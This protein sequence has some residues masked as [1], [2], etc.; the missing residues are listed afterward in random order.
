MLTYEGVHGVPYNNIL[1]ASSWR[2][3]QER[4]GKVSE[5]GE[6][7]EGADDGDWKK[8]ERRKPKGQSTN[9]RRKNQI[10]KAGKTNNL[11]NQE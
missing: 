9:V 2:P 4:K 3:L 6:K 1:V 11:T 10:K 7:V 8:E 5:T